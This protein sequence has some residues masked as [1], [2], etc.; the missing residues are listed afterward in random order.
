[1]TDSS[2]KNDE[3]VIVTGYED[4]KKFQEVFWM[5]LVQGSHLS[6]CPLNHG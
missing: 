6:V 1:M 2:T 5:K 4:L 3:L